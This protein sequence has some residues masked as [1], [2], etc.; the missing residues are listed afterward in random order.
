VFG[1]KTSASTTFN[2]H[3]ILLGVSYRF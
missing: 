3:H 1:G 2:T